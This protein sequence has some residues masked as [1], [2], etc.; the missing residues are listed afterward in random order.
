MDAPDLLR[1]FIPFVQAQ[2]EIREELTAEVLAV[3]HQKRLG[4][5]RA[6]LR[7][8]AYWNADDE[9]A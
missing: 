2:C 7:E 4:H 5:K 9:G 8:A 6:A 3:V 1:A